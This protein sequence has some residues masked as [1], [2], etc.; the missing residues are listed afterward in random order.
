[1]NADGIWGSGPMDH[2]TNSEAN[3]KTDFA[4]GSSQGAICAQYIYLAYADDADLVYMSSE[5]GK[6]PTTAKYHAKLLDSGKALEVYSIP[7]K[8][9]SPKSKVSHFAIVVWDGSE[10]RVFGSP[11]TPFT[12]AL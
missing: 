11:T 6:R 7:R 2:P 12:L 5:C 1:M 8:E 9:L 3:S 4:Y 10:N